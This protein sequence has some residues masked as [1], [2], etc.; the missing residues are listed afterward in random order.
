[1]N[2]FRRNFI[3]T[4]LAG[5]GTLLFSKNSLAE[6][7]NQ[8]DSP[9]VLYRELGRTGIRL[10]VVSSG[11]LP[12]NSPSLLK[13]IMTSGIKHIDSAWEY[14]GG[15]HDVIVGN[16]MKEYGRQNFVI[17]SKV[18]MPMD[19][20]KRTYL[21][22]ATYDA[23][24]KQLDET[25]KKFDYVDILYLHK[26]PSRQAALYEPMLKGLRF[27][28]EIGFAKHIGLSAHANQIEMIDAAID[29]KFYE[30]I[31]VSYNF[32]DHPADVGEAIQRGA[33][34]G[35][36]FIAMKVMA[37]KYLDSNYSEP[38]HPVAS[39]KW[40]LQNENIASAVI[41]FKTFELFNQII[42]V[43]H[44]ISLTD[45]ERSFLEANRSKPGIY[46]AGCNTCYG[47]CKKMLAIPDIM[48]AYMYYYGYRDPEKAYTTLQQLS[49]PE[50][51]CIACNTCTVSCAKGFSVREKILSMI[52][53]K[54][55][56][57]HLV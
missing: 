50:E 49:L 57:R 47:Q 54:H 18:L 22:A 12:V 56:Y 37:G 33:E 11:I 19:N 25:R 42:P 29:S 2:T 26:P 8:P 1:M 55:T 52:H 34:A 53:L 5:L 46:C 3:K 13:A 48:R 28:K 35:L 24:L 43:L 6:E 17:S 38:V 32:L 9:W 44:N 20:E 30:V 15:R 10:P 39:L 27:A 45:E 4:S 21:P 16:L 14:L 31:L 23:F 41:T 51:A 7:E 40:V 36:G